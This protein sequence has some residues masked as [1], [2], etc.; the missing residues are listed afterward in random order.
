MPG[1]AHQKVFFPPMRNLVYGDE[2]ALVNPL[3]NQEEPEPVH[4]FVVTFEDLDRI[5]HLPGRGVNV[6]AES[7]QG[8]A[9]RERL[10]AFL[11]ALLALSA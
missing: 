9:R 8:R 11:L 5:P 3:F 7:L 10:A 6:N 2:Q 1:E 4:L